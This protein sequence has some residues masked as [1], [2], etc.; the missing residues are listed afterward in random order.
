MFQGVWIHHG[1]AARPFAGGCRDGAGVCCAFDGVGSFHLAEEGEHDQGERDQLDAQAAEHELLQILRRYA[2]ALLS[3][4]KGEA[5]GAPPAGALL[6]SCLG[7]GKHMYGRPNHDSD[8]FRACLGDVPLAGFFCNGEIGPVG[9]T[10]YIH[11]FTSSFAI[12]RNAA[13]A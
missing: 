12:F 6:F 8:A 9:G 3:E 2:T 4:G 5:L 1:G 13:P 10:T 11:G 7:R